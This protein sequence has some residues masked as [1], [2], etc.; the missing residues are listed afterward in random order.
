M[1]YQN[2]K[3]YVA[4]YTAIGKGISDFGKNY[5]A[6]KAAQAKAAA[7]QSKFNQ[8]QNEKKD[9][10]IK[11]LRGDINSTEKFNN[12]QVQAEY[13]KLLDGQLAIL[14]NLPYGS[15]DYNN[16]TTAIENIVTNSKTAI[17]LVN[18]EKRDLDEVYQW[19]QTLN[20]GAGGYQPISGNIGGGPLATN[21]KN[22]VSLVKDYSKGGPGIS[23]YGGS[24]IDAT[25]KLIINTNVGMKWTDPS[26][27]QG[28]TA[29][30]ADLSFI[31][32]QDAKD[33]GYD[34]IGRTNQEAFNTKTKG[35][36]DMYFGDAY[37]DNFKETVT[38]TLQKS[39]GEYTEE[40][41]T[42]YLDA[43]KQSKNEFFN[44]IN[45][46]K[47]DQSDWQLVGGDAQ[48]QIDPLNANDRQ[49]YADLLW[50]KLEK[51]NAI[52]TRSKVDIN[53]LEKSDAFAI[54]INDLRGNGVGGFDS[55]WG[56]KVFKDWDARGL[57]PNTGRPW[58]SSVPLPAR[59]GLGQRKNIT[60]KM[61]QNISKDI[62]RKVQ[63]GSA[64]VT[65]LAQFLSSIGNRQNKFK[66]G[67][68]A[69][70]DIVSAYQADYSAK[71]GGAT[72][73][74]AEVLR[75]AAGRDAQQ[76]DTNLGIYYGADNIQPGKLFDMAGNSARAMNIGN[77]AQIYKLIL[78]ETGLSSKELD[79]IIGGTAVK[80]ANLPTVGTV[81]TKKTK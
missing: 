19:D 75:F 10:A 46:L 8:K 70:Q 31:N 81:V 38:T 47:F 12:T 29:A 57:D 16:Q 14:E 23:F 3:S 26:A 20:G 50:N 79:Y 51:E 17:A 34:I 5:A 71:H 30:T 67:A 13:K 72:G 21:D 54:R 7:A 33:K 25:G 37:K 42:S 61:L 62:D 55:S 53:K 56:S 24:T 66:S 76:P 35:Y 52:A 59:K 15:T 45:L 58:A 39:K 36:K 22:M 41:V 80:Q 68:Q 40:V 49:A 11:D 6:G 32:Y 77:P 63:A 48:K 27:A 2:P 4:D 44:N 64:G 43:T 69:Q 9:K 1:S 28:T 65:E 74:T 18:Q 78:G 73:T 60:P